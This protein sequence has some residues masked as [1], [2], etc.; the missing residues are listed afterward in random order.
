MLA[1]HAENKCLSSGK[2]IP[3]YGLPSELSL[4]LDQL[5]TVPHHYEDNKSLDLVI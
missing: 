4:N 5:S 2:I 1:P 3:L